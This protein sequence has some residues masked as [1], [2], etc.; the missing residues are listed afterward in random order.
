MCLKISTCQLLRIRSVP[1]VVKQQ[2]HEIHTEEF[3]SLSRVKL[4]FGL[5]NTALFL[6]VVRVG[7]TGKLPKFTSFK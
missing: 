3:I 6:K 2:S 4:T 1:F 7:G 5:E